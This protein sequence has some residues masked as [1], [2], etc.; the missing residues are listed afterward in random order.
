MTSEPRNSD[1]VTNLFR[2]V[3][4]DSYTCFLKVFYT[5]LDRYRYHLRARYDATFNKSFP[6]LHVKLRINEKYRLHGFKN[7]REF[8]KNYN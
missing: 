5:N 4:T 3:V 8:K 6:D 7:N 2:N 1:P